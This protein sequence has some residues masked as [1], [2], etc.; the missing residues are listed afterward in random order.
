MACSV[1]VRSPSI[2]ADHSTR[3]PADYLSPDKPG[4]EADTLKDEIKGANDFPQEMAFDAN[5]NACAEDGSK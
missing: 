3:T 5:S 2:R 1:R 4:E